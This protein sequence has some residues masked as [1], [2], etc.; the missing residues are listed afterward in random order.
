M[1]SNKS[2]YE[3]KNTDLYEIVIL[4]ENKTIV[5]IGYNWVDKRFLICSSNF[6]CVWVSCNTDILINYI[7]YVLTNKNI[8]D[9][10]ELRIQCS[11]QLDLQ[12]SSKHLKDLILIVQ[13]MGFHKPHYSCCKTITNQY[14]H[15]SLITLLDNDS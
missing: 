11:F 10:K 7:N 1:G 4:K 9:T 2:K 15:P 6:S 14:Y 12:Y 8:S 13:S 5:S 3:Q